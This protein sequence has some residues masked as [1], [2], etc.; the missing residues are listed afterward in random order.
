MKTLLRK[1]TV[2]LIRLGALLLLVPSVLADFIPLPVKWSQPIGFTTNAVGIPVIV[3]RDR[4]SD[5]T[6][7][8]VRADDFVC[9]TPEPIVAVRW[10][11]SYL[12]SNQVIRP[13][14]PGYTVPFDISFH[15]STQS[16]VPTNIHPFSLPLDSPLLLQPVLA[17]EEFVGFDIFGEAVYRYDAYLPQPFQQQGTA[18][19]P[20]EYFI[21]IDKPTHENWGWHETPFGGL[22]Y[23]AMA[24]GH[25]GPWTHDPPHDLAFELMVVPEPATGAV[26]TAAGVMLFILRRRLRD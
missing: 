25:F 26:F 15:L 12:G 1:F 8:V 20:M 4:L 13:T 23:P 24:P 14:S 11:G 6:M 2:P 16:L 19:K 5:H 7:G 17:Q 22:D 10:W 21:D 9:N 3:G 18:A